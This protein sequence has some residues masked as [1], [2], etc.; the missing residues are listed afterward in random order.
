M[1]ICVRHIAG[2]VAGTKAFTKIFSGKSFIRLDPIIVGGVSSDPIT[3]F[4][5]GWEKKLVKR[6]IGAIEKMIE[7]ISQE[8][9]KSKSQ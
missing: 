5:A 8:K 2:T 4:E 1:I 7:E 6:Q 3:A 9:K